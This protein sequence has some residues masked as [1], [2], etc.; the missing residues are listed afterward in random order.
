MKTNQLSEVWKDHNCLS[1]STP[2][3]ILRRK[4]FLR[5]CL[6]GFIT[7]SSSFSWN[8]SW[9]YGVSCPTTISQV[10]ITSF[11]GELVC[12][13]CWLA[14]KGKGRKVEGNVDRSSYSAREVGRFACGGTWYRE[15]NV[16]YCT[17]LQTTYNHITFVSCKEKLSGIRNGI[18]C[19]V[20][21]R[22]YEELAVVSSHQLP[23][24]PLPQQGSHGD[25][26]I[27]SSK[28]DGRRHAC[29]VIEVRVSVKGPCFCCGL[30][31]FYSWLSLGWKATERRNQRGRVFV[32]RP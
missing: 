6:L 3:G 31:E 23:L 29:V 4:L 24:P 21:L 5:L 28:L 13:R 27:G 30:R 17:I 9:S 20:R 12:W 32:A 25:D 18:A 1:H 16:T 2:D 7:Y 19:K 22:G 10:S 14:G 15:S 26:V 11:T 8:R